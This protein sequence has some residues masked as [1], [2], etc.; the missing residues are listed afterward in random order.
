MTAAGREAKQRDGQDSRAQH[1]EL[2]ALACVMMLERVNYLI[3]IGV[4]L[5][6]DEMTERLSEVIYAAFHGAQ[7]TGPYE[8]G[9][10]GACAMA[11]RQEGRSAVPQLDLTGVTR[12][13]LGIP[14]IHLP[15]P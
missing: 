15:Q 12:P 9:G 14:P 5:P 13:R 11:T 4:G 8:R 6:G 1:A 3:N 7:P 2:T 10:S